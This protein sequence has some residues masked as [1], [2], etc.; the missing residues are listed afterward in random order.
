M[1]GEAAMTRRHGLAWLVLATMAVGAAGAQAQ[2]PIEFV[3]QYGGPSYAIAV[4]GERAYLGIGPRLAVLDISHPSSPT[5]LG[6]SDPLLGVVENVA[7][8]GNYVYVA[9]GGAGLL[10]IDVSSPV[11]P[12]QVGAYQTYYAADVAVSGSYVCLVGGELPGF[13]VLDVSDPASPTCVGTIK[14]T[15]VP[16]G[17]AVSGNYAYVAAGPSGL[18]VVNISNASSPS[19][20]AQY[21]TG[22]WVYKVAV[23]AGY[24]YLAG[25]SGLHVIDIMNPASPILIGSCRDVGYAAGMAVSGN[26]ALVTAFSLGLQVVDV[27]IPASPVLVGGYDT[28]GISYGVTVGGDYAYVADAAAGLQIVDMSN[29]VL[30]TWAGGYNYGVSGPVRDI[31]VSGNYVYMAEEGESLRVIDVSNPASPVLAGSPG[32]GG[33]GEGI[34]TSGSYT[35]VACYDAGLKVFD[36]SNPASPTLVGVCHECGQGNDLAVS[37]AHA[38]L[39]GGNTFQVVDI[40]DPSAPTLVSQ[41]DLSPDF[42][43]ASGLSVSGNQAYVAD[44]DTGLTVIDIS[45]PLS[46]LHVSTY[47]TNGL[48]FDVSV[49]G[50]YAYV[51]DGSDGL[52]VLDIS[53]PLSPSLVGGYVMSWSEGVSVVGL[54]VP[55]LLMFLLIGM[56]AGSEGPG[57]FHFDDAR[58]AKLLGTLALAFI[59]FSGGLDTDWQSVRPVLRTGM[60]LATAGVFLTAVLV[61]ALAVVL[62]GFSWLEGLLLGSVI[63]STDAAA[64][65]AVLRSRSVSLKGQLRPLLELE[66]GSNDPMAVFLTVA[67]IALLKNPAGSWWSAVPAFV[68]QMLT[69]AAVGLPPRR[70]H[71]RAPT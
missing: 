54:G 28:P 31:A 2:G 71:D 35:Y 15:G 67:T 16:Q 8:S 24:A 6:K 60:V 58:T 30:P 56:L 17:V 27:S 59:L 26:Y 29:P 5:L 69:G 13:Q 41:C 70:A 40:L 25:N 4:Q 52:Q 62:L 38:Y 9:A 64:V 53:A 46:P 55:A 3:A 63:S 32:L 34:L 66:S 10:V 22:V 45:D 43:A 39:A 14:K 57:G 33:D 68:Q 18:I 47:N 49:V 21:I 48:A 42:Y 19:T 50:D 12:V 44:N 37:G 7:V 1:D 65:F 61:A 23:V 11:A 51:A 36:M 20:V